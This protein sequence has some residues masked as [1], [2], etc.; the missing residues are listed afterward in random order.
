[1]LFLCAALYAAAS[2][3][4]ASVSQLR[5]VKESEEYY[6]DL[7]NLVEKHRAF[8]PYPDNTVRGDQPLTRGEFARIFY[9][10]LNEKLKAAQ[11]INPRYPGSDLATGGSGGGA[12]WNIAN[13]RDVPPNSKYYAALR[14]LM[15]EYLIDLTGKDGFF[16]PD[17]TVSQ[18]EVFDWMAVFFK[19]TSDTQFSATKIVTRKEWI[20]LMS[21]AFDSLGERVALIEPPAKN[22]AVGARPE[23]RTRN[24]GSNNDASKYSYRSRAELMDVLNF[25]YPA[26]NSLRGEI[27]MT[28]REFASLMSEY[29]SDLNRAALWKLKIK[30]E[31]EYFALVKKNPLYAVSG[32]RFLTI[33]SGSS[34]QR[35]QDVN[36]LGLDM[37]NFNRLEN[38]GVDICDAA[39]FCRPEQKVTEREFYQWLQK[40]FGISLKSVPSSE[41][42]VIRARIV[43]SLGDAL[44]SSYQKINSFTPLSP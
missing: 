11:K 10:G 8:E 18:K 12:A 13:V 7:K 32:E 41:Q 15:D 43:D 1:M 5:D 21:R 4:I 44:G 17:A 24:S 35:F 40:I 27:P 19:A 31:A 37:F 23:N 38:L 16:R 20:I 22:K 33:V 9:L 39:L 42:P 6:P 29:L 25:H 14:G 2:A 36:A 28:R 34:G 26:G 3:Q 30:D